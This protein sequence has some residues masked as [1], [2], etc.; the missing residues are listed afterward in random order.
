MPARRAPR[1]AGVSWMAVDPY[2]GTNGEI[3]AGRRVCHCEFVLSVSVKV[4]ENLL[5]FYVEGATP[6]RLLLRRVVGQPK[7][8]PKH[9]HSERSWTT[10]SVEEVWFEFRPREQSVCR[11]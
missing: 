1:R 7:P 9:P 4:K 6:K 2:P 11:I 3:G 5:S 10:K 8:T